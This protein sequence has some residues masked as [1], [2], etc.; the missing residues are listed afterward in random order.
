MWNR[1]AFLILL[2]LAVLPHGCHPFAAQPPKPGGKKRAMKNGVKGKSQLSKKGM[3]S[4]KK[5]KG[6]K[7]TAAKT[8]MTS[9]LEKMTAA[10]PDTVDTSSSP[11]SAPT[12]QPSSMPITAPLPSP[13]MPPLPQPPSSSK[14]N[15]STAPLDAGL[16][17]GSL[18]SLTKYLDSR[19]EPQSQTALNPNS[20]IR[21]TGKTRCYV[22][23]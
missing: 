2:L 12:M 16:A 13:S 1:R 23:S 3:A 21:P 8:R 19:G 17:V 9:L 14:S 15:K 5:G 7:K 18:Y 22:R 11:S 4:A 6:S 10:A 20:Y